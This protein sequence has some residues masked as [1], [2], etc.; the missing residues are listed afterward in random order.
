MDERRLQSIPLF[1]DLSKSERAAVARIADEMDVAEGKRLINEG[2]FAYEFFAITYGT[3]EVTVGGR[4]V[5]DLGP[6]DIAGEM[7]AIANAPRN[8]TV[9]AK[10]P[11]SV[12]VMTARDLR[13]LE[14]EMPRLHERL[15]AAI[16]ERAAALAP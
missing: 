8:A 5:A 3:A 9:T 12:V 7:G 6:G 14:R 11:M 2:A 13:H 10:S 1:A 16:E 4:H 15:R